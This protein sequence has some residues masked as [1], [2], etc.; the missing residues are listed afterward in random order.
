MKRIKTLILGVILL[1]STLSF[2]QPT[3]SISEGTAHVRT[4][5]AGFVITFYFNDVDSAETLTAKIEDMSY[6][7]HNDSLIVSYEYVASVDDTV[8]VDFDCYLYYRD[9]SGP[10][11][12]LEVTDI[13]TDLTCVGLAATGTITQ[14]VLSI[15]ENKYGQVM[16]IT[17]TE[18]SADSDNDDDGT[19]ILIIEMFRTI[20]YDFQNPRIKWY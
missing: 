16:E 13:W 5:D 8:T 20:P 11:S 3:V 14:D 6:F 1:F 18:K 2:A 19:L 12:K 17:V 4:Y 9:G 15:S 10:D 7:A